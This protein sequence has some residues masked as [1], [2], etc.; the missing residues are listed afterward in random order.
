M[1]KAGIIGGLGPKAMVYFLQLITEMTD[2]K[3]DQEHME[4][5]IH[6][7]PQ[8]PDRTKFILGKSSENP[9]PFMMES[10][11]ELVSRGAEFIAIPCITAHYFQ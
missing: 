7:M 10:G 1:K 9:L 2:A 8:T 3:T 4:L 6:S 11:K 5:L